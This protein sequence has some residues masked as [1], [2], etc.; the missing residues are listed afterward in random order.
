VI[1]SVLCLLA[2]IFAFEAKLAWFS[3][4]G[5]PCAQIS[6]AKL[7]PADAPRLIAQV[8]AAPHAWPHFPAEAHLLLAVVLFVTMATQFFLGV[9]HEGV[10]PLIFAVFSPHLFRRP[11]PQS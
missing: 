9:D 7:Q 6:A 1:G 4:A 8:L 2:A 5:T 10:K 11:P 3:P